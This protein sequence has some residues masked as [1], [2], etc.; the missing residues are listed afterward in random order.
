MRGFVR[1]A[2]FDAG[3]P[4]CHG[5]TCPKLFIFPLVLALELRR[6]RLVLLGRPIGEADT[7]NDNEDD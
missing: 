6:F 7:C 3:V 2:A 4:P 1:L 5:D